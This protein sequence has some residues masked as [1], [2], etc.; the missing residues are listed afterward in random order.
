MSDATAKKKSD[1]K[2]LF[3]A[4]AMTIAI[5]AEKSSGNLRLTCSAWDD[6]RAILRG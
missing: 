5:K 4:D 6:A 3:K 1:P 2:V